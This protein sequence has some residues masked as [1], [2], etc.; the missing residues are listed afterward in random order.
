M[1]IKYVDFLSLNTPDSSHSVLHYNTEHRLEFIS[2]VEYDVFINETHH[3]EVLIRV[4][5][6]VLYQIHCV[7][8]QF[9]FVFMLT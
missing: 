7:F 2:A 3:E 8:V 4:L 6:S 5:K 1:L 9:A